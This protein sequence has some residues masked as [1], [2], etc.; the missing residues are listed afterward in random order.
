MKL[1]V[2][3]H[4]GKIKEKVGI[5]RIDRHPINMK[6]GYCKLY[7]K[8]GYSVCFYYKDIRKNIEL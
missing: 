2:Y 6:K 7:L 3:N 5:V 8:D 1:C 4:Q